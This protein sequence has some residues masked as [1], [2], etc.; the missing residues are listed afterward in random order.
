MQRPNFEHVWKNMYL[1]HSFDGV[2]EAAQHVSRNK[3]VHLNNTHSMEGK[4]PL[5]VV[6][7]GTQNHQH[8]SLPLTD[9][10]LRFCL[11]K[12]EEAQ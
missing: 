3:N 6:L 8:V 7:T 1:V 9:T 5:I 10:T 11:A 12:L 2:R 4:Y